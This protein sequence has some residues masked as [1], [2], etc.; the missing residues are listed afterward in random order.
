MGVLQQD[1]EG[2][3]ERMARKVER[4]NNSFSYKKW[5]GGKGEGLQKDNVDADS[6]QGVYESWRRG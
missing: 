3:L 4:R 5:G 1:M 2:R 6:I